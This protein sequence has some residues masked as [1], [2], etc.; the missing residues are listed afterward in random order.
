MSGVL[1][2]ETGAVAGVEG[3]ISPL[4]MVTFE[5]VKA[6]VIKEVREST[7]IDLIVGFL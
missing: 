5:E 7:P 2:S 3:P 6:E 4:P 1:T